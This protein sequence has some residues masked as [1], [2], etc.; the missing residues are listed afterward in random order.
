LAS[1][2]APIVPPT[3]SAGAGLLKTQN[4]NFATSC[5]TRA[6]RTPLTVPN[7]LM[8]VSAPLELTGRFVGTVLVML[9]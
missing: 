8:L 7:P 6:D 3:A 2:A 4:T 9:E 1:G 5:S